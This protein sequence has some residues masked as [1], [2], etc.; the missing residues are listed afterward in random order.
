MLGCVPLFFMISGTVFFSQKNIDIKRLYSHN[1]F[2]MLL[3]YI[4]VGFLYAILDMGVTYSKYSLNLNLIEIKSGYEILKIVKYIINN[5]H[6]LLFLWCKGFYHL[7]YIPA[8]L[9]FYVLVPVIWKC[10][11]KEPIQ[12]S[13]LVGILIYVVLQIVI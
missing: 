9:L 4:V 12:L 7:W 5:L 2:R 8:L 3:I 1:I 13:Y 6:E 10:L 11:H